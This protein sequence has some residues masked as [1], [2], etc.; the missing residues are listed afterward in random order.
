MEKGAKLGPSL[1]KAFFPGSLIWILGQAEERG[2]LD[3]GLRDAGEQ[4]EQRSRRQSAVIGA[5]MEP[6]IIVAL[7]ALVAFLVVA[8]FLP[9]FGIH[10]CSL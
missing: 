5:L 1:P 9:M 6:V 3:K 10:D 7:G 4:Q 2:S 8:L